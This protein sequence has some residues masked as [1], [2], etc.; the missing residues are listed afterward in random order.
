MEAGEV[1]LAVAMIS[2]VFAGFSGMI[3]SLRQRSSNE[4]NRGDILRVW[5]MIE[6]SLSALLF[7]LLP[8]VF[9]HANLSP[10]ATWASCSFMLAFVQS[11]QLARAGYRTFRVAGNDQTISLRFTIPFLVI[12]IIIFMLQVINTADIGFHRTNSP[13]FIGLFWQLSLTCVLFRRLLKFSSL[14]YSDTT[15][16]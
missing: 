4:W 13:Y 11:I 2:V 16:T 3:T 1:F 5:Q 6:V 9:Y 10:A 7:S 14:H 12:G 8:F 15:W